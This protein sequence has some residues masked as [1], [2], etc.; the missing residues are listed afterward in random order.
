MLH[1]YQCMI[2]GGQGGAGGGPSTSA[3]GGPSTSTGRP[4]GD[5]GVKM[6]DRTLAHRVIAKLANQQNWPAHRWCYDGGLSESD[7]AQPFS[8]LSPTWIS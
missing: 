6:P 8:A 4:Q 3:G 5:K 1:V 2:S 7:L